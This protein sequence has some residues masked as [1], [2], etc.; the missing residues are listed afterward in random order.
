MTSESS[1]PHGANL[2]KV[3]NMRFLLQK[4]VQYLLMAF[5]MM[6]ARMGNRFQ[7]YPVF[8]KK[9]RQ[10]VGVIA[11]NIPMRCSKIGTGTVLGSMTLGGWI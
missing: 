11:N 5:S 6:L 2:L 1:F 10:R 9:T 8:K 4:Y 3:C 7:S